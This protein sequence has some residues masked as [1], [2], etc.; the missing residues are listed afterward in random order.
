MSYKLEKN[1]QYTEIK[2]ADFI[3]E[4]N[5]RMGLIIE[6]TDE[7]IYALEKNEKMQ[8]GVPVINEHYEDEMAEFRR[9]KF[10]KE[11]FETSLGWIRRSV[12]MKDGSK[13]DFLS[14]LLLQIKAGLEMGV[15]VKIIAYNQ[16]DFYQ[17]ETEE[18][19]ET[20]QNKI[21]ATPEFVAECLNR[22]V[23]DFG[24]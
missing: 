18:Y 13:K 11:F 8:D 14:D 6:E 1:E 9:Q 23:L 20:L 7:A 12:N 17:D 3:A 10:E 19:M 5:H 21:S 15:D 24:S 22:T 16:P 4:Y 2:R